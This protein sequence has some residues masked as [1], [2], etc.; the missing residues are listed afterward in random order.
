MLSIKL[1]CT[2]HRFSRREVH[3][4]YN[5]IHELGISHMDIKRLNILKAPERET[6]DEGIAPDRDPNV[7]TC[8]CRIIDF[9]LSK[10]DNYT[11][12][13]LNDDNGGFITRMIDNLATGSSIGQNY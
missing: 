12:Q 11:I 3:Y 1:L 6:V 8:K 5:R 13:I 9:E 10:K 7:R 2:D 4:A